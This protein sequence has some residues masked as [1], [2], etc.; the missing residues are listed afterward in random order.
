[1]QK[2]EYLVRSDFDEMAEDA[3]RAFGNRESERLRAYS[4]TINDE[5]N[6]LGAEGWELIQAPD[7]TNNHNWVFKRPIAG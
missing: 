1:M 5:L 2:F 7:Q 3:A 4:Q 6:K